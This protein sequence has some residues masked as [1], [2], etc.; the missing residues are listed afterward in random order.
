[1]LCKFSIHKSTFLPFWISC[2][3]CP[4]RAFKV[5]FL[6]ISFEV[7]KLTND[8]VWYVFLQCRGLT[9]CIISF[10]PHPPISSFFT[11]CYFF[12][13]GFIDAERYLDLRLYG[14]EGHWF[15]SKMSAL[16]HY[17]GECYFYCLWIQ[18]ISPLFTILI[19]RSALLKVFSWE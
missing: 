7:V 17:V 11:S 8:L 15:V 13:S 9:P 18:S 2:W 3:Y 19:Q 6:L 14:W 10:T 4:S 1:M 16:W 5:N 12:P